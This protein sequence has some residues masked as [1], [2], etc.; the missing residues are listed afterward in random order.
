MPLLSIL[1]P[2]KGRPRYAFEA[3]YSIVHQDFED[4]E[5]LFSNNGANPA[6]KSAISDFIRDPRFRYIE[7]Q[8]VLDMPSHWDR[9]SRMATGDHL[10]VVTDRALLIQGTLTKLSTFLT[11]NRGVDVVNWASADYN[12]ERGLLMRL[13]WTGCVFWMQSFDLLQKFAKG[14]INVI[15]DAYKLPLGLN[16]CVSRR[17]IEK[18]RHR[19][20]R[21]FQ[22][23]TPDYRFAF[24]CLLNVSELA[25]FDEPLRIAQGLKVSNGVNAIV[26]DVRPYVD[27]LK[28]SDPW[29]D[30][31]I[32]APLVFN[33]INRDFLAALN[34]YGRSDIRVEWD[35]TKYYKDCLMEIKMKKNAGILS[36]REIVSLQC[37]VEE[38]VS[39]EE[40]QIRVAVRSSL[41]AKAFRRIAAT[42]RRT[43]GSNEQFLRCHAVPKSGSAVLSALSVAG[44]ELPAT[45][46]DRDSNQQR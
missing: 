10:L 14:A 19:E 27:S 6:V 7:Q 21:V 22:K 5:I 15:N 38:A 32:K 11:A 3:V 13:P 31:P 30:V 34:R 43:L 20:D 35:R 45:G 33:C 2:A 18:I 37:A 44:F 23:M 26:G 9:I 16:S 46:R 12:E 41:I 1:V 28:I 4:F 42:R 36:S 25:H 29:A 40:S 8:E 24:S 17:L 39:K